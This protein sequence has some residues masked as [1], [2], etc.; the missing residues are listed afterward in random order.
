M[1]DRGVVRSAC[2][3]LGLAV[4][5]F[6]VS[7]AGAADSIDVSKASTY[8]SDMAR[9]VNIVFHLSKFDYPTYFVQKP[10]YGRQLLSSYMDQLDPEHI[11]FSAEDA[12]DILK[13]GDAMVA[14]MQEGD[15]TVAQKVTA[16]HTDRVKR[17]IGYALTLIN[18]GFTFDG[19]DTLVI[20][21]SSVPDFLPEEALKARWGKII[22]SEWLD[23]KLHG[24]S[25]S[26]IKDRL[27]SRYSHFSEAL[28]KADQAYGLIRYVAAS[29]VAGDPAGRYWNATH[30]EKA[31]DD[32]LIQNTLALDDDADGPLIRAGRGDGSARLN[33]GDRLVG[34]SAGGADITYLDGATAATASSL[35]KSLSQ[36]TGV[37]L[38]IRRVGTLPGAPIVEVPYDLQAAPDDTKLSMRLFTPSGAIG[39]ERVA[40][41]AMPVMYGFVHRDGAASKERVDVDLREALAQAH[42][43]GVVAVVFDLRDDTGGYADTSVRVAQAFLGNR[44]PWRIQEQ[45]SLTFPPLDSGASMAWD[46]PLTVLVNGRTAEGGEMVAAALQD[47]GRALIVGDKTAGVASI[48]T[49][50]DLNRF[51][52][53]RAAGSDLGTLKMTVGGVFRANGES[54]AGRGVTPDVIVPQYM[55]GNGLFKEE[56]FPSI[57]PMAVDG[58]SALQAADAGVVRKHQRGD[59]PFGDHSVDSSARS[60]EVLSLN[61]AE[62][63]SEQHRLKANAAS[64]VE[65][66]S[67][68]QAVAIAYEQSRAMAAAS[69]QAR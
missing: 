2:Q 5:V 28:V 4:I 31:Q 12:T 62:R 8:Q 10:D 58:F 66:P 16:Q 65:D 60:G 54:I 18:Q 24:L 15:V 44:L 34:I 14:A 50:I 52:T 45:R 41:I 22:K 11:F 37:R 32:T 57:A 33:A 30:G 39:G 56:P 23:L 9:A 36:D 1:M 46:G 40:V 19:Q 53:T 17:R 55:M 26:Q 59:D 43:Q 13:S 29:I 35:L 20:K 47:Y 51:V 27:I 21:A 25:D 63:Q 49:A 68:K 67:I 3:A 6:G 61:F 42:S 69:S 48:G 64:G 38:Y 7:F